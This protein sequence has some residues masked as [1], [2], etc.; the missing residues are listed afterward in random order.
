VRNIIEGEHFALSVERLGGYRA[1]D[2]ALETIIE[3]LVR[4]P[5]GFPL[6]ENDWVRIRYAR[7]T[8]IERYIP[9][10]V[11]AFT[12]DDEGNVVLQWADYVDDAEAPD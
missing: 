10:L 8:M 3:A 9:P 12:L 5:Y 2:L 1:I 4:N 6:I 7:T 11:V